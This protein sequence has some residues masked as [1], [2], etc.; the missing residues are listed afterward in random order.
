MNNHLRSA[1]HVPRNSARVFMSIYTSF[2]SI[3]IITNTPDDIPK[4]RYYYRC[5]IAGKLRLRVVMELVSKRL[6]V[7]AQV[8]VTS[9]PILYFILF[10][11]H[12]VWFDFPFHSAS[13]YFHKVG[14][15]RLL[16]P[17]LILF[18]LIV[19]GL[20]CSFAEFS[21][22]CKLLLLLCCCLFNYDFYD[23]T[24]SWPLDT[25]YQL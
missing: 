16:E 21:F 10:W 4:V 13:P 2:N 6:G 11:F 1:C 25:C 7:G 23:I 8:C 14:I 20:L 15:L 9:Q 22:S 18:S 24:R 3:L 19:N 5:F 12:F 17:E